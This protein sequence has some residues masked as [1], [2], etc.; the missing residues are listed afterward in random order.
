MLYLVLI[1]ALSMSALAQSPPKCTG[2]GLDVDVRCACHK[3]PNS[4]LCEMV[5]AGFYDSNANKLKPINLG[6]TS[7]IIQPRTGITQ[8][9]AQPV[10]A[11]R[12]RQARVAPLAH[13]DYLRFLHPNAQLVAGGA[14][15][16]LFRSPELMSGV[17]GQAEGAEARNQVIAA[18]K[19]MDN[20]WLSAAPGNDVVLLMTG[21]FEQGAA[22]GMFYAKGIM[23]VF[24]GGSQAMMIGAEPSLQAALGRLARPAAPGG[25]VARRARELSKDHETWIVSEPSGTSQLSGALKTIRQFALGFR[26]TGDAG[27]D[28]E[29]VADSESGAEGIATWV[30]GMKAAIRQ[31][32]GVGA[33]DALTIHRTGSTLQFHASDKELLAGDAGK[34]A[35]SSDFGVELYAL[36]MGAFPGA[37]ARMVSEDKLL[38]VQKGMK[39]E[40][41]LD[42]LGP[43]LSVFS[44]QG[45]E[46]PLET[47]TYQVPFGKQYTLNLEGG[48]VSRPLALAR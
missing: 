23:P 44:I 31:K 30:D 46:K 25:W 39:R 42:L 41:V 36:M 19:E 20:L 40:D 47:W 13:K 21:R 1:A 35:L 3:D 16:K 9:R 27:V 43:P 32:T 10:Q 26:L 8:S 7:T 18:L 37:Q 6:L 11:A 2:I 5:K 29:V 33:L 24:L 15:G 48:V 34:A 22:A 12:P 14:I 45:M 4:K 17:F 38:A 28:G